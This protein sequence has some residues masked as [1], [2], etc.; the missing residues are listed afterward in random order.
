MSNRMF[1][2]HSFSGLTNASE[3]KGCVNYLSK[4]EFKFSQELTNEGL[5]YDAIQH[6][7][8]QVWLSLLKVCNKFKYSDFITSSKKAIYGI[9]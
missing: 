3:V 5:G 8:R 6:E 4:N 7:I 1:G 9:K 2:T